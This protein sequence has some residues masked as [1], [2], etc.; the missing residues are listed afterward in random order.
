MG[1]TLH[2]DVVGK[3]TDDE[4]DKI[5]DLQDEYNIKNRWTCEHLSLTRIPYWYP[6]WPNWFKDSK[7]DKGVTA[8]KA[9]NIV[10]SHLEGLNGVN[11]EKKVMELVNGRLL[12]LGN[13]RKE[14][15]AASG[16]TKVADNEWNAKLVT[17]FFIEVSKISRGSA[18]KLHDEGDYILCQYIIIERGIVKPDHDRIREYIVN[19]E[20]KANDPKWERYFRQCLKTIK[21]N[22]SSAEK[23]LYFAN[24]DPDEYEDHPKFRT[25]AIDIGG[26]HG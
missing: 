7:L 21:H 1:R 9:W 3:I 4:W 13:A 22:L 26:S 12:A 23:G 17:D 19:L 25:L 2:Y 10:Y 11:L 15:I 20:R 6:R 24:L 14:G 8:D 16:F 18:V 5:D